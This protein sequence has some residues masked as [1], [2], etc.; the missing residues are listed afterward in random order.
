MDASLAAFAA[1]LFYPS[2]YK[3]IENS[4]YDN[5]RLE[6]LGDAFISLASFNNYEI[7]AI[8]FINLFFQI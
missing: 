5:E 1:T 3:N 8:N 6:F 4:Q 2:S 7:L